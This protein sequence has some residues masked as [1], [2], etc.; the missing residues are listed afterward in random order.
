MPS[1]KSVDE[2]HIIEGYLRENMEISDD[3]AYSSDSELTPRS[4]MYL[5]SISPASSKSLDCP[6]FDSGLPERWETIW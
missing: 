5:H 6:G 1:V 4:I 3:S 2:E